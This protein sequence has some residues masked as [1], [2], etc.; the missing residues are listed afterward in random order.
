MQPIDL[1]HWKN[2]EEVQNA[3]NMSGILIA[4]LDAVRAIREAG[5]DGDTINSHPIVR[6]FADKV[7]SVA[8]VQYLGVDAAMQ[9]HGDVMDYLNQGGMESCNR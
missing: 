9:A 4:F 6:A 8:G 2:A 1:K 7:A 3:C 5:A